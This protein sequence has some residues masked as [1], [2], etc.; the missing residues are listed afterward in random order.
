MSGHIILR[1]VAQAAGVSMRTA[2]RVLNNDPRVA[3]ATRRRVQDVIRDLGF[4]PDSAAR[5]LRAG[6]DATIGLVVES[7][8][9]PFFA[10]LVGAVELAASE[11]GRSVLIAS[12][13]RD[14]ARERTLVEQLIRRR[15][16]GLILAPT[17]GDHS[18]LQPVAAATPVVLVDRPADGVDADLVGVDDRAATARAVGHLASHGHRRIA[19]VGDHPRVPTSLARLAGYREAMA[20]R[21]LDVPGDL[22]RADC[23]DPRSAADATRK[24]LAGQAPTAIISA[25]TRCSLGVVP[26]LHAERRTDVALVSFGDFAMADALQPGITVLDHPAGTVGLAAVGRLTARLADPDLPVLTTHVPV[27]LIQRGSG[28]LTA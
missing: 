21:G 2:S 10:T 26:A 18:W 11:A 4:V 9:D 1:D 24:L 8:D 14:P 17:A 20:A 19:Y 7:V 3:D 22:V 27:R 25:A 15:V 12:T 16:A 13:H 6:T 28:E 5:S 23:P